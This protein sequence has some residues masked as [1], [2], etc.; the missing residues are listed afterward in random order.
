MM[1]CPSPGRGYP[2]RRNLLPGIAAALALFTLLGCTEREN[3]SGETTSDTNLKP[4]PRELF[5]ENCA[6][7]HGVDG[8]GN[9]PLAAEL[10]VTPVNLRLLKQANS[11]QFPTLK[12][13]R[14]IDGR[15]MPKAHGLPEMPV[16][17]RHWIREGLT[18]AEVTA[19]T[20]LIASYIASIQ[21]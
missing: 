14:S 12:V 1:S 21:D 15:G 4:T 9:G 13:Q 3:R 6:T 16:W 2:S 18:E 8:S 11:G 17:G 20:V 5:V 7:C 10:R 19:R